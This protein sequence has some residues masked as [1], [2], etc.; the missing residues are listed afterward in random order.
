MKNK[1][2][3]RSCGIVFLEILLIFVLFF[4]YG[5]W[6]VPDVNEQ[7]YIGKAI[8]F[9]NPEWLP[10]DQFLDTSDSHWLFYATFGFFSL[11]FS[12]AVLAW[13]GRIV[14]WLLTAW[15]W[16]S[17]SWSIIPRRWC[18][19]I[20]A[21]GLLFYMDSYHLAGEWII[22]GVEGKG[23][24]FPFVFWGL[25]AFFRGRYSSAWIFLGI[26][27]AFHVLVGGW[28]VIACLTAWLVTEIR[29]S[30]SYIARKSRSSRANDISSLTSQTNVSDT[31]LVRF[32][33]MFP[34]LC[35]GGIL[36]LFGLIPALL[37]DANASGDMLR[38]AHRIYVYERL[39]HHLVISSLPWTFLLRFGILVVLW[40]IFCRLLQNDMRRMVGGSDYKQETSRINTFIFTAISIMLMGM[41]IDYGSLLLVEMKIISDHY[42]AAELLRFYWYR[43]SDWVVPFGIAFGS[44]ILFLR[45]G[46]LYLYSAFHQIQTREFWRK[47]YNF[48]L[49]STLAVIAYIILKEIWSGIAIYQAAALTVDPN[50]PAVPRPVEEVA[51]ISAF[52]ALCFSYGI[53]RILYKRYYRKQLMI[54]FLREGMLSGLFFLSLIIA[55]GAPACHFCDMLKLRTSPVIPRSN[56]P[57]ESISNGWIELCHWISD[58][59]N[60]PP[61]AVFLVPRGCDSFKW[62]AHRAEV[63]A[64]KEIPQ[65][66]ASIEQWFK[67]LETLYAVPGKKGNERWNQ[68]LVIV[69]IAKGKDRVLRECTEFG[70]DYII[71][72]NPPYT[73][74]NYSNALKRYKDLV[75]QY[76]IYQ[77]SHFTIFHFPRIK[78]DE[79]K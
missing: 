16:R 78:D 60:T 5:A 28:T 24:A 45:S 3:E 71:V 31:F 47:G 23:V 56:P 61:N 36:S 75:D 30:S 51:F 46:K 35:L 77:N 42:L 44:T 18:S 19:V 38:H 64:W 26:A 69:L 65:D 2:N 17:L 49:W 29:F 11:F 67:K 76:Q 27:S 43:L 48:F 74:N 20:T 9:W 10:A 59:Q 4:I 33:R 13:F 55:V 62:N 41:I 8:H 39:S 52:C 37:L 7:Y 25:A 22:G 68:P 40:L 57:K 32:R 79:K 21:M 12:P 66:A 73:L 1:K 70:I 14:L 63:V 53:V 54:P 50:Y 15:S 6:P 34:G 72:E 58:P